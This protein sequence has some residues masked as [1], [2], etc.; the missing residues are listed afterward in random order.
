MLRLH[1][2]LL[3]EGIT[4][5]VC[6]FVCACKNCP[7][8]NKQMHEQTHVESFISSR[9][10]KK[11]NINQKNRLKSTGQTEGQSINTGTKAQIEFFLLFG[12]FISLNYDTSVKSCSTISELQFLLFAC[13][14]LTFITFKS[15][16]RVYSFAVL[17]IHQ[18]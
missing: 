10:R 4:W 17:L 11:M 1:D 3:Y 13:I 6:V 18:V 15:H 8:K 2:F 16:F 7:L 14:L 9:T 5:F 12:P